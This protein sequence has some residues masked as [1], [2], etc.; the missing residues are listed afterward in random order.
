MNTT[1][2]TTS[3]ETDEV[4]LATIRTL[5]D[6]LLEARAYV[7]NPAAQA[8]AERQPWREETAAGVLERVDGA[9]AEADE[10]LS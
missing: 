5:R 4:T 9:L 10:V 6:A 1:P 2:T 3:R 7:Y 8:T